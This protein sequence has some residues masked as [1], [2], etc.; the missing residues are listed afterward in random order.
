MNEFVSR[1]QLIPH[2]TLKELVDVI[3]EVLFMMFETSYKMSTVPVDWKK[4]KK[5]MSPISL[6]LLPSKF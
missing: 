4:S 5:E 1:A 6:S 3:L 2:E